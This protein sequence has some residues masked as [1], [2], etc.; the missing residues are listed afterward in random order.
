MK[1]N[2]ITIKNFR[3]FEDFYAELNPNLTVFI[4][5]NGSGKSTVLDAI[6]ISI[7]T[8]FS[9]LDGVPG[10][11]INKDDVTCKSFDMGTVIDLQHQYP[12]VITAK[13]DVGGE[14]MEWSRS[15]NGAGGRTTTI[16]A[17][18]IISAAEGYQARIREGDTSLILPIISYY[19]TG[20]LWAQ[21]REKRPSDQLVQFSRLSG[22]IDCL[23]AE[24]NEKLM[25][26]WFEKMTIQQAQRQQPS[27]ELNAVEQAVSRCFAGITGSEQVV[28]Q[29]NLDTHSLDILYTDA[30]G[31]KVRVPMKNLSDG[32]KNTI[33]M[34]ADIAYRMAILNP[35]L[36]E[37]VLTETPGIVLIDEVDLHL[38]PVWQQR[39]IQDLQTLFPKVQFI[40]S[41]H[42]P[43]VIS[44]VKRE[45]MLVLDADGQPY[46]LPVEVYGKD[47][48]SILSAVMDA[49]HRPAEVQAM[50]DQFY[51]AVEKD[52]PQAEAILN[53]IEALIGSEDPELTQARV[54]LALEQL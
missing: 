35:Q 28:T 50:F 52:I 48:N 53:E 7:G 46:T 33:G 45:N 17:K 37:N 30:S 20:R 25:L 22:Y 38:H 34:I 8:F 23:A 1:I 10:T 26:K 32:Y 4:G 19:G 11:G 14:I 15:L 18:S 54:T 9:G 41:T 5:N 12:S 31:K 44:S 36:L 24:S 49:N 40:V 51:L 47:A 13:G 27:P 3:G 43:S 29:F 6:S 16:D 39:I 21:K 2:E 42:A